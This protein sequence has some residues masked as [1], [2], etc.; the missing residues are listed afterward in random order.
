VVIV[1]VGRHS[2]YAAD[3][4][5]VSS[6]GCAT[7]LHLSRDSTDKTGSNPPRNNSV[8]SSNTDYYHKNANARVRGAPQRLP[9]R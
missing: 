6:N 3:A 9:L 2:L 8:T 5:A 4:L 1:L 7:P